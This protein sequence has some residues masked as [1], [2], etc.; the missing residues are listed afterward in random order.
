MSPEKN[1]LLR[2][3]Y[4]KKKFLSKNAFSVSL[5]STSHK[6][7]I[8]LTTKHLRFTEALLGARRSTLEGALA[9]SILT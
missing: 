9:H 5:T 1:L 8:F 3:F 6:N 4:K 2:A 7:T